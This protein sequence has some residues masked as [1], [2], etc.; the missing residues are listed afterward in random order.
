MDG[1]VI[2]VSQ[3]KKKRARASRPFSFG[4][5]ESSESIHCLDSALKADPG[6]GSIDKEWVSKTV[7]QQWSASPA[8]GRP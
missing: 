1:P 8:Y 3:P 7:C 5:E 2:L 6:R 4:G